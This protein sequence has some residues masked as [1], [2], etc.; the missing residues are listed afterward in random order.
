VS[1]VTT[2][3][4]DDRATTPATLAT[5]DE[6][7]MRLLAQHVPISLLL[8]ICVPYGPTSAEILRTEGLPTQQWWR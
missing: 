5:P 1:H 8:D 6:E 4:A 7:V 3:A 2:H